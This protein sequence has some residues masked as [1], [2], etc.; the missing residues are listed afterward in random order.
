[1]VKEYSSPYNDL[2]ALK[3]GTF[4]KLCRPGRLGNQISQIDQKEV[5]LYHEISEGSIKHLHS[6]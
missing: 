4:L 3:D 6:F 1:M 2:V 5:Q